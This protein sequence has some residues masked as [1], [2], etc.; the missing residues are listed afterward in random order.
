MRSAA[1][2]TLVIVLRLE[3]GQGWKHNKGFKPCPDEPFLLGVSRRKK[4]K[5]G[6]PTRKKLNLSR[7]RNLV[8]IPTLSNLSYPIMNRLFPW[9]PVWRSPR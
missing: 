1:S 4:V 8:A 3:V 7:A 5:T 9:D 2:A 6:P